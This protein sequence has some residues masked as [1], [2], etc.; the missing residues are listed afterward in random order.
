MRNLLLGAFLALAALAGYGVGAAYLT[1]NDIEAA[2]L[3]RDA[4]ALARHLDRPALEANLNAQFR[5]RLLG[6]GPGDNPLAALAAGLTAGLVDGLVEKL[7]TP[8][9]LA[10]LLAGRSPDLRLLASGN[11]SPPPRPD[12]EA[13]LIPASAR[14]GFDTPNQF[15][16]W[17]PGKDGGE[18][19]FVLR[20]RDLSWYL[21]EIR[22]PLP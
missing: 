7:L 21:S 22:L 6:D 9:G 11:G 1:V 18:T 19:R 13:G 20:R 5:Q 17:V 3:E 8:E 10:R 2:A 16:L 12:G 15:S 14:R 4:T